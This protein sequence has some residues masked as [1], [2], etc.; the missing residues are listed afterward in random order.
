MRCHGWHVLGTAKNANLMVGALSR[1]EKPGYTSGEARLLCNESTWWGGKAGVQSAWIQVGAPAEVT[2]WTEAGLRP[3]Y[4]SVEGCGSPRF[5]RLGIDMLTVAW[6]S[7]LRPVLAQGLEGPSSS[8]RNVQNSGGRGKGPD[9]TKAAPNPEVRIRVRA[10]VLR[11]F[12]HRFAE[13]QG[14]F[15]PANHRGFH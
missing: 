9:P 13:K 15:C 12:I 1:A 5:Q 3:L 8:M 7:H 10:S 11:L 4:Q 2:L 14:S 6:A